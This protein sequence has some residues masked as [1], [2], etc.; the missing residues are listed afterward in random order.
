MSKIEL[1]TQAN[2][3]CLDEVAYQLADTYIDDFARPPWNEVS[4]CS[5]CG[6]FSASPVGSRCVICNID[7]I[8]AYDAGGL[9]NEWRDLLDEGAL[10]EVLRNDE[11]IPLR[12][13]IAAPLT[14]AGLFTRKYLEVPEMEAWLEETLPAEVAYIY[15]TFA[16]LR[17][18]QKGNLSDRGATLG[19][20]AEAFSGLPIVMRTL[21]P[22]I[23]RAT[24]RDAG[25]RTDV[26][27]GR[28]EAGL[29]QA[30]GA[31]AISTVPDRRTL[32]YVESES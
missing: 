9:L 7:Q 14:P 26:Y 25:N 11:G 17:I 18:S 12:T 19:R 10:I 29:A 32:L 24:V 23:I 28:R 22:A 8:P 6:A 2:S 4:K 13:T 5:N 3:A 15:D 30:L 21:Q 31:R 27:V 1:I 16:N 20:I